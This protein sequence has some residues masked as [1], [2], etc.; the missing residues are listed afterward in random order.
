MLRD[1]ERRACYDETG[2][3]GD[4][5]DGLPGKGCQSFDELKEFW[6]VCGRPHARNTSF[7]CARMSS[8]TPKVSHELASESAVLRACSVPACAT[9]RSIRTSRAMAA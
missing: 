4:E 7:V 2:F 9:R 5:D 3:T 6:K 1:P 8:Q